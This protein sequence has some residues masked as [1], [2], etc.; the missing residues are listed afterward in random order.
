MTTYS[1][2]PFDQLSL[3]MRLA[4][5]QRRWRCCIDTG[6]APLGLTQSRWAVLIHLDRLGE[7]VRQSA[8]AR[9]L[10]IELPSLM[11]TLELLEQEGLVQRTRCSEDRR[12]RSVTFTDAG[13]EMLETVRARAA[14][15]E[16]SL[17]A[18]LSEEEQASFE[19]MLNRLAGHAHQVMATLDDVPASR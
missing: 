16:R 3:G 8:L 15:L 2:Q 5:L 6:M 9:A 4:L 17:L 10:G 18:A 13:R 1:E 12:A 19:D 11:R 14:E 7:G